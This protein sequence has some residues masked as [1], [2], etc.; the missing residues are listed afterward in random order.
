M[1]IKEPQQR[2]PNPKRVP[3]SDE[4]YAE[5][6][7]DL[8]LQSKNLSYRGKPE[9]K[10]TPGDFGL[11]PPCDPRL[12]K[13]YCDKVGIFNIRIALGLLREGYKRG[14]IDKRRNHDGLPRHI[15]AVTDDGHVLE[16]K[17]SGSGFNAYHGYPM[18]NDDPLRDKIFDLWHRRNI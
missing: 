8:A 5:S 6:K 2:K 3:I 16:A 15:W 4:E 12:A 1:K 14:L 17:P 10:E 18:L 11:I 9:H 13:T 7:E